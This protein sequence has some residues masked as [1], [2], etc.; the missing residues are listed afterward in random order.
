MFERLIG[1]M[2]K[3]LLKVVGK[4]L[5]TYSEL[6]EV[7]LDVECSMNNRPPCYQEEGIDLE[8][9]TPDILLRGKPAVL[10][11]EDVENI[12]ENSAVKRMKFVKRCKEQVNKRWTNEYIHALEERMK[13]KVQVTETLPTIGSIILLKDDMKNKAQWHIGRIQEFIKGKDGV[14]RGLKLKHG[15]GNT[16]ERPI[17][18]VCDMEIGAVETNDAISGVD[19]NNNDN[20]QKEKCKDDNDT[21]K[22]PT[23]KAK[24][25][26]KRKIKTIY[27][28][29]DK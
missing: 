10:L 25:I 5:L 26:A 28:D 3:S 22:R 11:E 12:D 19:G 27:D 21:I 15:N 6:E 8:V 4:G 24:L 2:K 13:K 18:M 20:K 29:N 1:I 23:R 9:L 7:L 17:Q 16:I 14:I